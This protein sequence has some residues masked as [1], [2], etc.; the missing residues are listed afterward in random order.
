M[1]IQVQSRYLPSPTE[2]FLPPLPRPSSNLS[3]SY[4]N[5]PARPSSNVSNHQFALPPPPRTQS[6]MSNGGYT[7]PHSH[8]HG[9]SQAGAG[10]EY[11]YTNGLTHQSSHEEL[12]RTNSAASQRQRAALP[13]PVAPT[14]AEAARMPPYP[15][16]DE[17]HDN[18]MERGRKRG[19]NS[20][21]DWRAFF[22]DR[23]PA[24]I[25]TI[26]D[27][28]SP[29][30]PDE[31]QGAPPPNNGSSNARHAGK[32]RRTNAAGGEATYSNTNT[33][34][35]H[36]NHTS[37][38]SLQNT[39]APTSLG[40]Q[41]SSGSRLDGA[42]T[43]Q[44][45]KRG[46]TRASDQDRK[47]QETERAGARGYLEEYG[48]YVPPPKQLRKQKEVHV[49]A[50]H[51]VYPSIFVVQAIESLTP[52]LLQRHRT[53]D[54]ID[55]EDG[56][57]IVQEN[58]KLGER[59]NLVQLLGQGTFGKVVKALDIRT[60]REVA[61]KIIRAVPKVRHPPLYSV[62]DADTKFFT[63]PRCQPHR[64]PRLANTARCRRREPQP[65]HPAP[66]LLRLARAHMYSHALT[67]PLRLRLPEE[68][69]LRPISRLPYSG[70]R[71]STARLHRLPPRPQP[72]PYRLETREHPA[73][74]SQLSDIYVQQEHTEQYHA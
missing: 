71:P 32:R 61:V 11:S 45:R 10:A 68:R 31:D 29:V 3:N 43:G 64:A 57:Y 60:R 33:P 70:L 51:E 4:Y 47:R 21:V 16:D 65:L 13:P 37:T 44:K 12:K 8:A 30:P 46:V 6:G 67:R 23:P 1:S 34:Y 59:Y 49:P 39:T 35:S 48:E 38:E 20:P 41:A 69:R 40:S 58:S 25:I 73:P 28:D 53:H 74:E 27:D 2:R 66:T 14:Q 17:R 19:R 50:I 36:S 62:S 55:D 63:V 52:V 5:V 72:D 15:H 26:H 56:H 24:E 9:Q 54:K 7:Q 42:Q 22:G 18:S